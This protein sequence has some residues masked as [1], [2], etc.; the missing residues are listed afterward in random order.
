MNSIGSIAARHAF[1]RLVVA[2]VVPLWVPLALLYGL[3]RICGD[4]LLFVLESYGRR[5]QLA[6][7]ISR[8]LFYTFALAAF[9]LFITLETSV[10]FLLFLGTA[11][12]TA[13]GRPAPPAAIALPLG[14]PILLLAPLWCLLLPLLWLLNVLVPGLGRATLSQM[15][16]SIAGLG[17]GG[18][19][20]IQGHSRMLREV[21]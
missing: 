8:I 7:P 16:S 13:L 2:L 12:F 9:P 3:G 15:R 17:Q 1:Q 4:G 14:I 21:F 5:P 10:A 6:N 19:H 20:R 18:H 11:P